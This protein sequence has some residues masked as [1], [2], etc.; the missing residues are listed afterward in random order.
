MRSEIL[1]ESGEHKWIVL[2][3]DNEKKNEVIDTNEYI[4]VNNGQ[5]VLL[6]PGGIEIFP[7]V[8]TEL[9][10]FVS[11]VNIKT[12]VASHQDPDIAS[13]LA[14]WLDLVPDV[15]IY[16]SW[17]WT[18]FI[19]H[20]GMGTQLKL[21]G[22][23]DEGMEFQ[24]GDTNA[25]LYLV[26]AHFCHSSGNYSCY[27][28]KANI[29]FSGDIGASLNPSNDYP[30]FV[31][32]FESHIQ[33]MEKFHKRWMPSESALKAWVKR[34]RLINPSMI[35]PQHGSIFTGE[36]VSKFLSW[37]ESLEVAK[38]ELHNENLDMN[39]TVWMKW[40]K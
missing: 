4:V 3:R 7:Q 32:N 37:L 33:L 12:I 35:C 27:D 18:G 40:K 14:M 25:M 9:T 2:G 36:N 5:A 19:A 23:P 29:L 13:S 24:I 1:F 15:K 17:I 8:L 21:N 16:C 38:L 20:F 28:P 26:P 34:V 30:F 31:D 22:V 6:D 10:R 39:K 11:T